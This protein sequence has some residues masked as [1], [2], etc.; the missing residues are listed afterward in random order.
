VTERLYALVIVLALVAG[1]G[2]ARAE[3]P[4]V[5]EVLR[6]SGEVDWDLFWYARSASWEPVAG[7][8]TDAVQGRNQVRFEPALKAKY[9]RVSAAVQLQLR[10]DFLDTERSRI[11][12][13]DAWAQARFGGLK[14]RAGNQVLR[15]GRMDMR[16]ALDLLTPRDYDELWDAERLAAPALLLQYGH[17]SVAISFAW[18]PTFVPSRFPVASHHRWNVLLSQP[19]E[20]VA[21]DVTFPINYIEYREPKAGGSDGFLDS[22]LGLRV[23]L[24]LPRLDLGLQ[25]Y[26]GRD[27]LPSYHEFEGLDGDVYEPMAQDLVNFVDGVDLAVRPVHAR[28]G[29]VGGDAALVLGPVVLKGELAYTI[30]ADPSRDACEI[31]DP[32]L[33]GTFGVEWIANDLIGDQ[34]LQIRVEVAGDH[35]LPASD[36]GVSNRIYACDAPATVTPIID[37]NHL[38]VLAVYGNIRWGFTDD[39]V[40]DIRGFAAIEGDY[41]VRAE[42]SYTARGHVR[43]GLAGLLTGG[44]DDAF[45]H[46]YER[47]DRVEFSAT[48]MF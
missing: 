43:F 2:P 1:A 4:P 35:E 42:L 14:I 16:P 24:F 29:V 37:V 25:G 38:S 26:Y 48:Y 36:D 13:K 41:L 39:L 23:E 32:F 45:M 6:F 8:P 47:N 31:P 10:H 34:D 44:A 12:L 40:L 21:G 33:Q 15:W 30:T 18:L 5:S 46:A 9:G 19:H 17:P 28:K 27:L 3:P 22:Q 7:Q 20:G 11:L